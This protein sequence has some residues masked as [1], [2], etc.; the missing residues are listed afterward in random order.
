MR[1]E[2]EEEPKPEEEEE[3]ARYLGKKDGVKRGGSPSS[4]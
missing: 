4:S 3:E 1:M 2:Q